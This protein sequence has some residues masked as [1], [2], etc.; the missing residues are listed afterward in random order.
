[1]QLRANRLGEMLLE[2]GLIDQFQ[3]DSAL[4]MQ[5]NLG[6]RIGSALV[7][8]G[9][10][11]EDTIMEFLESQSKFSRVSLHDL[12]IPLA[13]MSILPAEKLR[14]LLVVP[15][16]MRQIGQE[17]TLRVAMTDP[18]NNQLISNLQFVTGC[19]VL[20][21]LASEEEIR[22]ALE[23]NLPAD[24]PQSPQ[25]KGLTGYGDPHM[26]DFGD[27]EQVGFEGAG[28]VE[29]DESLLAGL[30]KRDS[31]LDK[32]LDILQAKGVLSAIDVER[33]KYD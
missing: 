17:K 31:R 26:I 5:R 1:M 25:S 6:G 3:L 15:I 14:H 7:K 23:N 10:L 20:P 24:V 18:T 16:E 27:A 33:V 32:L 2:A 21:V 4:S 30:Q 8:L 28:P 19:R 22:Q 11:P 9:Y 29:L 13:V 12:D